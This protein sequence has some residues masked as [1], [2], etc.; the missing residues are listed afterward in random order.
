MSGMMLQQIEIT[1][2]LE[3]DREILLLGISG[4]LVLAITALVILVVVII[5]RSKK[6]PVSATEEATPVAVPVPEPPKEQQKAVT[7]TPEE[8]KVIVPVPEPEKKPEPVPVPEPAPQPIPESKPKPE[9]KPTVIPTANEPSPEEKLE[10]IRR[11]LE[12]IRKNPHPDPA[13]VLPKI[14]AKKP[15]PEIPLR[16]E[17][18]VHVPFEETETFTPE[19]LGETATAED[20]FEEGSAF[21]QTEDET[22]LVEIAHSTEEEKPKEPLVDPLK[23]KN[24][25]MKKLTF[26]EWVELFKE[27]GVG[28]R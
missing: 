25:P 26:A 13:P 7:E 2:N 4:L 10:E 11:R 14:E 5:R 3:K 12:E 1:G 19:E 8:P 9:E 18:D 21:L 20:P 24:L 23:N 16:Q 15:E 22:T 28:G 27:P 17:E 6:K